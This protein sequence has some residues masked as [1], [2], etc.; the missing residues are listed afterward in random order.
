[1][2]K[3]NCWLYTFINYFSTEYHI[4]VHFYPFS[5]WKAAHNIVYLLVC[6]LVLIDVNAAIWR[7]KNILSWKNS[8][9]WNVLKKVC[10]VSFPCWMRFMNFLSDVEN[11]RERSTLLKT[12]LFPFNWNWQSCYCTSSVNTDIIFI[13]C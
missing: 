5:A 3:L 10:L 9:L 2:L 12:Q 11:Q 13:L 8:C 4:P 6:L 7:K 1:M